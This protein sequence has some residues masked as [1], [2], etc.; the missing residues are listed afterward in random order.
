MQPGPCLSQ[1]SK[2]ASTFLSGVYTVIVRMARSGHPVTH[3]RS[4]SFL[5][6]AEP[7]VGLCGLVPAGALNDPHHR[8]HRVARLCNRGTAHAGHADFPLGETCSLIVTRARPRRCS[9]AD[10]GSAE[11]TNRRESLCLNAYLMNHW[12]RSSIRVCLAGVASTV[13]CRERDR[14][15]AGLEDYAPDDVPPAADPP[16]PGVSEAVD[17]AE[18]GLLGDTSIDT[19]DR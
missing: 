7:D 3:S 8:V 2:L 11:T 19:P 4:G 10:L 9:P 12:S 16:P 18:R 14:V 15:A 5:G 1:R 17:L 6:E 13:G